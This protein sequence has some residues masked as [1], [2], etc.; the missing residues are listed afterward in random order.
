MRELMILD[1]INVSAGGLKLKVDYE[2]P[3]VDVFVAISIFHFGGAWG[4]LAVPI[5]AY[6]YG[7]TFN[8]FKSEWPAK[9]DNVTLSDS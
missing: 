9:E 5:A 7:Y 2:I 6:K 1:L 4:I 8:D 3:W